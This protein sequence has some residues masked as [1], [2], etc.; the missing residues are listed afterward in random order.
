MNHWIL[1][2]KTRLSN[3][4]NSFYAFRERNFCSSRRTR[5]ARLDKRDKDEHPIRR[6]PR[7]TRS[8]E[9]SR[10]APSPQSTKPAK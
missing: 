9:Y 4:V 6:S 10:L 5:P 3:S 7:G 8:G 2:V 1:V